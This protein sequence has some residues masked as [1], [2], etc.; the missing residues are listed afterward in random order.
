MINTVMLA[1]SN[2]NISQSSASKERMQRRQPALLHYNSL[3]SWQVDKF[4]EKLS[5]GWRLIQ[6]IN[7]I[8]HIRS[9]SLNCSYPRRRDRGTRIK[10]RI[11]GIGRD[12]PRLGSCVPSASSEV[13]PCFKVIISVYLNSLC[14]YQ[15][16]NSCIRSKREI[17]SEKWCQKWLFI[18]LFVDY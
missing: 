14:G 13:L 9:L 17:G 1:R 11:T 3:S 18:L 16:M 15:K 12:I 2:L 7:A 10:M 8:P 5:R 6:F 4:W